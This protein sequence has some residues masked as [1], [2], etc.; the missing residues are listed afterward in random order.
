MSD[1]AL[2]SSASLSTTGLARYAVP[3]GRVLFGLLFVLAAPGH[4]T[5]E[6]ID[7][8]AAQG[9]P[10]ASLA[11]PLSGVI[12]AL[13]G[14]GIALGYRTRISAAL[15]V[16]FLVP[17]TIAMHPFWAATDPMMAM[18]HRVMFLKNVALLGAALLIGYFG[19]GPLSLDARRARAA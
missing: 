16:A 3:V 6:T 7:M 2:H 17:V 8:A 19:A 1:L 10:L 5:S 15:L 18:I 14:L 12:S 4:F 11:V 9:V 13:G